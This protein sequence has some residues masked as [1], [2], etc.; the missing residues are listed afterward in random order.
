MT[1]AEAL[2][3]VILHT[4]VERYRYLCLEHPKATVRSE[5]RTYVLSAAAELVA[6]GPGPRPGELAP[7]TVA[8]LRTVYHCPY[9][10]SDADCGCS[11]A[12]CALKKAARVTVLDCLQC[13]ERYP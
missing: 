5:Y 12:K 4:G 3:V 13:V 9:R 1:L 7:E 2:D 11:G 8:R 10:S 6:R